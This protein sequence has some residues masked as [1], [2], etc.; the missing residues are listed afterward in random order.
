MT[1]ELHPKTLEYINQAEIEFRKNLGQYFT[2]KTI[3]NILIDNLPKELLEKTK[4]MDCFEMIRFIFFN[5]IQSS[6]TGLIFGVVLG[7]FPLIATIS[8][9]Y[10]LGFVGSMS[11]S[12][13]GIASLWK[14]LP[15]G[16]FELPAIFIA[17]GMGIKLGSFV[18][19]KEAFNKLNYFF[20]NSLRVFIF[21]VLPLLV[22]AGIIEGFLI[23][24]GV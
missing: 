5:N 14:I 15:H 6:F 12:E 1:E 20:K 7:I 4:G 9:G 19:Y 3:R 8:N 17:L 16:I 23:C 22:I 10:L 13:L 18:F 11:V 21:V 2:I 24:S